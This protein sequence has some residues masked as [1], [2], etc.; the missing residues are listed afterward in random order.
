M[1]LCLLFDLLVLPSASHTSPLLP[2]DDDLANDVL[3]VVVVEVESFFTRKIDI[4]SGLL[5]CDS[6]DCLRVTVPPKA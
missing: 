5:G 6:D 4:L 2:W 1:D 3:V